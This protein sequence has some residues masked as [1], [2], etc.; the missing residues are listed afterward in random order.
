MEVFGLRL[1]F[2]VFVLTIDLRT[3][4]SRIIIIESN[5]VAAFVDFSP[6]MVI[7]I[8]FPLCPKDDT[9]R[10]IKCGM[11]LVF[12]L[13]FVKHITPENESCPSSIL[14][15]LSYVHQVKLKSQISD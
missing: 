6:V 5:D 4:Y 3:F 10:W 1:Q 14:I 2:A 11:V 9:Q 12:K 13:S 15:D 8:F 7:V